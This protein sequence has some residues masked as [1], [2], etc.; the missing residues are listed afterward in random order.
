L[1]EVEEELQQATFSV[2]LWLLNNLLKG[3]VRY[4]KRNLR[5]DSD[6]DYCHSGKRRAVFCCAFSYTK[7]M[8]QKSAKNVS[9]LVSQVIGYLSLY[10]CVHRAAVTG[11]AWPRVHGEE[12]CNKFCTGTSQCSSYINE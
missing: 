1:S 3:I 2:Y 6:C 7:I 4:L 8:W 9:K 5:N 10:M 11:H 12:F